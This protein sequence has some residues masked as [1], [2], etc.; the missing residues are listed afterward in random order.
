[1]NDPNAPFGVDLLIPQVGGNARKTNVSFVLRVRSPALKPPQYDYQN[2][3]L[4]E[5]VDII[6]EEKASLFVCAVGV[7]PQHI[8]D[9]L[10]TAGIPVM[11]VSFFL[12]N[13]GGMLTMS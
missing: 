10:H 6:I 9:K 4:N 2:G 1:L 5:L 12:Y 3:K 13:E 8:V 11:N 7:P